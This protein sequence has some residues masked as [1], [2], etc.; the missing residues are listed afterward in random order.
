MFDIALK[1]NPNNHD[2]YNNKGW[3]ILNLLY[4]AFSFYKLDKHDEAIELYDI[5]I[6]LNPRMC[7]AYNNKGW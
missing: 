7:E 1:L 3:I 5:A 4:I 2:T 6:Q